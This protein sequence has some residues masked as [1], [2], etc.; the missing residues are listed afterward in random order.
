ME[1]RFSGI[2]YRIPLKIKE[3][4]FIVVKIICVKLR[5]C[6]VLI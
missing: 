6:Y 3:Y 2:I 4:S 5:N 1:T